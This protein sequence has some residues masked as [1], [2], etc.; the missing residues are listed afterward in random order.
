[1]TNTKILREIQPL[2]DIDGRPVAYERMKKAAARAY[3]E[4]LL[5]II[6][7]KNIPNITLPADENGNAFIDKERYPE[8]YDWAVN[9]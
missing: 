2:P 8:L 1:M 4:Q 9:G 7:R 6:A 3:G 5:D